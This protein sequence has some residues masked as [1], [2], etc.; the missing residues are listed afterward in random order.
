MSFYVVANYQTGASRVFTKSDAAVFVA[1]EL[2]W[3]WK[4]ARWARYV[5]KRLRD[6][7]YEVVAQSRYRVFGRYDVCLTPDPEFRHRF[8][9]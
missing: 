4:A 1:A 5:P 8:I 9:D 7:A 3:P 6:R 2:G